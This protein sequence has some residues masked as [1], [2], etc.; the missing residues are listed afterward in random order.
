M[1]IKFTTDLLIASSAL[2]FALPAFAQDAAVDGDD[3]SVIMVT[4]GRVESAVQDTPIAINVYSGEALADQGVNS[5]RDLAQIDPSVNVTNSTGSAYVA[6]RGI[7]ST[8]TTEIG[9]PSVPIARDGFFMNRSFSISSSMYDIARIEVLKGPQGTLQGRNSTGGL[10]SI[11]TNRPQ[12]RNGGYAS[13]EVGNFETFNGEMGA[14]LALSDTFAIR[15]SGVYLSHD[16]YHQTAGPVGD[17]DDENFASGRIQAMFDNDI[18]SLW[19]SYQHDERHVNG[20]AQFAFAPLGLPRPSIDHDDLFRNFTQTYTDLNSD[21]FRWEAAYNTEGDLSFIY[22]GGYDES[23]YHN[24][25]DATG[26]PELASSYPA[27][28]L[29]RQNEAPDTWNHEVRINNDRSERLFFQVGYFYFKENNSLLTDLYNVEM[30]GPFAPGGFL[31]NLPNADQS[32]RSGI[33]FDYNVRTK[34]QAVFGQIEFDITDQLEVSLGGRYTWD[35]KRRTGN[36]TILLPALAFPLCGNTFPADGSCPPFPLVTPGNGALND[37]QPTWHAGLNYRPTDDNLIYAKYDRGYKSGGF[38]SAGTGPSVPYG[39][40][41]LDAFEIGTKNTLNGGALQINATAFYFN[42]RGYQGSQFS[43]LLGGGSGIF[44]VGSARI[45]GL[46]ADMVARLSDATQLNFGASFLDTQFGDG[47]QIRNGANVLVDISGNELPNAPGFSATASLDHDFQVGSGT[48]TARID[49]KYSSSYNFSV[50]NN[51]DTQQRGYALANA[52][53]VYEPDD[54][55][56]RV[57]LYVRNIFDKT[58]L[59]NATQNF[60]VSANTYQLQAPRT[61]GVRA[62]VNF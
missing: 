36:S 61:F 37:S 15:A 35:D 17:A 32:G 49:G 38:N 39:P 60:L 13:V 7:A 20:D 44:N 12:M 11:I 2:A 53:L 43:A 45:M 4:A 29:F 52:S 48:L 31:A 46:E 26:L 27:N 50:F 28:Q 24:A 47:I 6:V 23:R 33:T 21:R 56:W 14:N 59:A 9:D 22:S 19:A 58:V 54:G 10:V 57:Q 55:L 51:P 3:S 62:S 16:G 30:T 34:S 40:E 1:R 8:D 41:Q 18:I 42:Y 25:L 5:V